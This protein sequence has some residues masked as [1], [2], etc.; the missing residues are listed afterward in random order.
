MPMKKKNDVFIWS[1]CYFCLIL[2]A[3]EFSEQILVEIPNRK[4]HRNPWK[5]EASYSMQG[6]ERTET[7]RHDE[8]HIRFSQVTANAP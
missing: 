4:F 7:K 1:A 5:W 2:T 8:V 3:I 6:D